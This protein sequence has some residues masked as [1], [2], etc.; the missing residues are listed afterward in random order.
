MNYDPNDPT[1]VTLSLYAPGKSFVYVIGDFTNWE[2][3]PAYF[4]YRD[5]P[6]PDS[7]HWWITIEGLTPGQEYAFQY[8]IDGELRLADLF[9]HKVLDPWH[10][11]FI[12]S[13]TYPNLKPYP[14]GKTEDRGRAATRRATVPVAGDRL[15]TAARAR[16]GHLRIAHS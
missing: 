5:A 2:V 7:V 14:T 16:A 3:D 9:A 8:F 11:P 15:R 4:M 13:S 1:R 12:P 6:R 10:D